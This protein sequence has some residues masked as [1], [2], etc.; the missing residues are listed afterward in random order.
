MDQYH[1]YTPVD[2][3]LLEWLQLP[4]PVEL[5]DMLPMQQRAREEAL[6]RTAEILAPHVLLQVS[7]DGRCLAVARSHEHNERPEGEGEDCKRDAQS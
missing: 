6:L 4:T 3:A 1:P 2:T 5:D 7:A